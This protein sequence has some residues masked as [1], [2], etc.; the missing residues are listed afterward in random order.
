[1]PEEST[2]NRQKLEHV[3]T[4]HPLRLAGGQMNGDLSSSSSGS[5]NTYHSTS[6]EELFDAE[7]PRVR[8]NRARS[9]R[10]KAREPISRQVFLVNGLL[11]V[12]ALCCS[13]LHV[14]L[15][16]GVGFLVLG[17]FVGWLSLTLFAFE[18]IEREDQTEEKRQRRKRPSTPDHSASN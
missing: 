10:S 9:D 3:M 11:L 15:G 1:M 5:A 12:F 2:H 18:V 16:A 17:G 4:F 14:V 7:S 8:K 6:T 13:L